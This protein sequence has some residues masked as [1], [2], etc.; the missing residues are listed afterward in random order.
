MSLSGKRQEPAPETKRVYSRCSVREACPFRTPF[1]PAWMVR[2][3]VWGLQRVGSWAWLIQKHRVDGTL[4]PTPRHCTPNTARTPT[5]SPSQPGWL[6]R[7]GAC[8]A[9]PHNGTHYTGVWQCSGE[10]WAPGAAFSWHPASHR[11]PFLILHGPVSRKGSRRGW[12]GASWHPAKGGKVENSGCQRP[13]RG[14]RV[15]AGAQ[16]TADQAWGGERSPGQNAGPSMARS[17][18]PT[19]G[20]PAC[21]RSVGSSDFC[22]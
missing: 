17:S 10:T 16:G 22:I 4:G 19:H 12:R 18:Q 11:G 20:V 8:L 3:E 15:G 6:G 9:G 1:Y 13:V 5:A 14:V 21:A 7:A 2:P